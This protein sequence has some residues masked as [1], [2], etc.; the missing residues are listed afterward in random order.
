MLEG[1]PAAAERLR[2]NMT[3]RLQAWSEELAS[4]K[5]ALGRDKKR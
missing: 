3:E 4:V 1:Y 2:D 5:I